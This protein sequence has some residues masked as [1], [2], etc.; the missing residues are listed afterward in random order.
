MR[1]YNAIASGLGEQQYAPELF[2]EPTTGDK[3]ASVDHLRK[4]ARAK[5]AAAV[6]MRDMRIA[7]HW[8]QEL[9]RLTRLR[10]AV[11]QGSQMDMLSTAE[12]GAPLL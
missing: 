5:I 2:P 12:Q 6:K 7:E 11:L 3:V 4:D 9:D 8:R 10:A 1:D